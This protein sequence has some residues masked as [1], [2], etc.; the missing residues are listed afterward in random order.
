VN[1]KKGLENGLTLRTLL[2]ST[3]DIH[4]WWHSG[5][6]TDTRRETLVSGSSSFMSREAEILGKW[7]SRG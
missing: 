5:A 4:E 2:Q 6:V 7:A 3:K 1:N